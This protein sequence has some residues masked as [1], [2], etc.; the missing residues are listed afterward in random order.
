MSSNITLGF[1]AFI[2]CTLLG[3][4]AVSIPGEPC[5]AQCN[6]ALIQESL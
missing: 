1:I 2:I 4:V 3:I 5:D 6:G